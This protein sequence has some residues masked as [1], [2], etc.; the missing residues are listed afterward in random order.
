MLTD[1]FTCLECMRINLLQHAYFVNNLIECCVTRLRSLGIDFL[2]VFESNC[3]YSQISYR[4]VGALSQLRP[5]PQ[6][7]IFIFPGVTRR[8]HAFALPAQPHRLPP[9]PVDS[10][11]WCC[12]RACVRA[13]R[14]PFEWRCKTRRHRHGA[15]VGRDRFSASRD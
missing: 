7:R 1:R 12:H 11:R 2:A 8:R 13:D 15:R 5:P 6:S 3:R 9:I 14:V 10:V 4:A